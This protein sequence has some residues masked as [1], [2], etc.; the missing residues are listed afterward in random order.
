MPHSIWQKA[1][2]FIH[3]FA[4]ESVLEGIPEARLTTNQPMCYNYFQNKMCVNWP[5]YGYGLRMGG[6]TEF[7]MGIETGCV[8][9]W[10]PDR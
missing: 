7:G 8:P 3:R 1:K 4:I 6:K 2:P 10:I 5:V 9:V